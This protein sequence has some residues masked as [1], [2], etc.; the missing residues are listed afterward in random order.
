M[1]VT[2]CLATLGFL[3]V[4]RQGLRS[5]RMLQEVDELEQLCS[6]RLTAAMVGLLRSFT[7]NTFDPE[8]PARPDAVRMIN[9]GGVATEILVRDLLDDLA[10]IRASLRQELTIGARPGGR[11][12]G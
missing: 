6:Q 1:S 7:V 3:R 5:P 11:R 2:L 12:T 9:Q 4:Y 8:R 10:Q